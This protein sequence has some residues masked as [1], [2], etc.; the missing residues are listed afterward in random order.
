MRAPRDKRLFIFFLIA[1][2]LPAGVLILVVQ[3]LMR[4]DAELSNRRAAD[5]RRAAL[6]QLRRELGARLEAI[7][8]QEINR[9]IVTPTNINNERGA[10]SAI[11]FVA[12]M[13]GDHMLPPWNR[14]LKTASP[15]TQ[16]LE[17]RLRVE[18]LE[19]RLHDYGQAVTA[20]AETLQAAR[21]AREKC[22][23]RL[24]LGRVLMKAARASEAFAN[25][26]TMLRE[27]ADVADDYGI[28]FDLYAAER[29]MS[30]ANDPA[31]A[32][33]VVSV[34]TANRWLSPQEAYLV[35]S[36][37]REDTGR[38]DARISEIEQ[39]VALSK[40]LP[41][42]QSF[43][44]ASWLAFGEEPWLVS[45][46]PGNASGL[47][48]LLFVVSSQKIAP[49]MAT[50]VAQSSPGTEPLG[51]GFVGLRVQWQ[52]ERFAKGGSVPF[53]LYAAGL[54]LIIGL[55]SLAGYVLLRDMNRDLRTAEL[56]THFIASVSH[57][58]KT[59]LTAVR[60][61]AETLV[62]GRA[63]DE[64]TR[65]EYL[66][67]IMNESERL[68]RLVDNVLDFSKIEQSKKIYRMRPVRLCE[69]VRSAAR[70]VQYPL[71][72]LGFTLDV[73]IDE[74]LV[75]VSADADAIEQAVLNLLSNAMKY[76]GGSRQIELRLTTNNGNAEI[77]VT[78]HGLGIAP[79]EQGRIFDKFYRVRSPQTDSVG[80]AGLGLALVKHI[81]EA[82][83]GRVEV[84][85][86][87]G[88][89]STF[90]LRIPA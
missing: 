83:R 2:V 43:G 25:Y 7:K 23:A 6:E 11:V 16:F 71:A 5:E 13:D 32:R 29:L 44:D 60:M 39:V 58:L 33:H 47:P 36:L 37:L 63:R 85:S 75:S 4:Q 77:A 74:T 45:V 50:L 55:T 72:Q 3:R 88:E 59:P 14:T 61:F 90:V 28:R 64:Q 81:A 26:R 48:S 31:G 73:S 38:I 8:L 41:R 17:R 80:G 57:E 35:R 22:E 53:S 70:V 19:F 9:R 52:A 34:A 56:R 86:A 69:V 27:C 65:A 10:D 49:P 76:S 62:L 24:L 66:E 68:T 15:T 51:E 79:E 30:A 87:L 46:A 89:G 54:A 84:H 82:H 1:I 42:V 18:T 20:T 67:T 21:N 40:E 12:A 78:D